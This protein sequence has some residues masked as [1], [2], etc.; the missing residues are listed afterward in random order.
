MAE[1]IIIKMQ[2]KYYLQYIYAIEEG[3]MQLSTI[4]RHN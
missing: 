1:A 3:G 4:S 2:R